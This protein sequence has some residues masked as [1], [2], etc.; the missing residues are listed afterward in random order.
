MDILESH[1]K[2]KFGQIWSWPNLVWPNLVITTVGHR[3][4]TCLKNKEGVADVSA[5][6]ANW[7]CKVG[8][9]ESVGVEQGATERVGPSSGEEIDTGLDRGENGGFEQVRFYSL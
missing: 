9:G 6:G 8:G 4:R 1:R 2:N 7:T 5:Q 3:L